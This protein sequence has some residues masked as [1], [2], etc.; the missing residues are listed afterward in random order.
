MTV[1]ANEVPRKHS[2]TPPNMTFNKENIKEKQR[3]ANHNPKKDMMPL[4]SFEKPSEA[5]M[6][7]ADIL[8]EQAKALAALKATMD[9]K[10]VDRP[11]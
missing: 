1:P 8:E 2:G 5:V 7:R 4:V 6:A 11:H 9:E 10:Q 3:L